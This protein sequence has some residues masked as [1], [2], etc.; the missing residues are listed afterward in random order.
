MSGAPSPPPPEG[1]ARKPRVFQLDDPNLEAAPGLEEA[2]PHLGPEPTSQAAPPS[3]R[4]PSGLDAE[5]GIRWGFLLFSALTAAATFAASL[6]FYRFVSV[7]LWRDDWIGWT[8]RILV[9]VAS[10]ALAMILLR[11]MIGYFRLGRL[12]RLKADA[13]T[14]MSAK[15]QRAEKAVLK[16]LISLY[17]GRAELKWALARLGDH[18]RDVHDAGALLTLADRDVLGEIDGEARRRITASARRVATVTALSPMALIS[19]GFVAVENMRLLRALAT[20]YGGRPGFLGSLKLARSV[21]VHLVATGGIAMTD[22]LLGQFIGQ[23]VLRRLSA[24]LGEGVFNGALTA[25]VGV[26][27]IDV[28]R[29][30]PFIEARRVRVRDIVAE[31]AKRASEE[32]PSPKP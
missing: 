9:G 20:I 5:R 16:R 7:G 27:A 32:P 17:G 22:D 23:D 24:R 19:V 14:A 21:L 1:A 2:P 11:E 30:L 29:P 15:N 6:W 8:M 26:A 25:R 28:I 12:N 4:W 3:L 10:F 13:V 18:S 31:I